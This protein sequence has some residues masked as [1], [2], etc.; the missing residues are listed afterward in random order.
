M[1]KG[2]DIL[3]RSIIAFDTGK[4]IAGILDLIFDQETN[5][6]LGFLVDEG[7]LFH[8]AKV[9]P[10]NQ[11]KAIGPDVIVVSGRDVIVSAPDVPQIQTILEHKLVLK[12]NRIITTDGRYLG[13]IVDL[14]FNDQT[15][16]IEGYETS[17]G[18]FADAYSGRSFIPAPQTVKIGKEVTFVPPETADLMA[19]QVGG[20]RGAMITAGNRIQESTATAGQQLQDATLAANEQLQ[21]TATSANR[22][23]QEV[24]SGANDRFDQGSRS[25]A[26]ELTD[27]LVSPDEQF[28]YVV[29]KPVEG[30][31]QT[32]DGLILLVKHQVV[33]LSLAEEARRLGILDQVY[34]ATGGSLTVGINRQLQNATAQ[35]ESHLQMAA[36]RGNAALSHLAAQAGIE[37]A[38]GRRVQRMVRAEDGMIIAAPGQIVTDNV[39][40]RAKL[41]HRE[42]SLLDAV[43]LQPTEATRY[44]ANDTVSDAGMRVREQA[45]IAQ[46][47][48]YTFW[49]NLK[50]HY[51]EFQERSAKAMHKQRIEQALGRPVNRV[52]LDSQDQVILNVGELITHKAIQQAKQGGV[53]NILLNSVCNRNPEILE[54]ELRAPERGIASLER[55]HRLTP[56]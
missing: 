8:A 49:E 36:Q 22:K 3:N 24:A 47:N 55:E 54:A 21:A 46:E 41:S 42:V 40:E 19:E 7:G 30:D 6:L 14:Y 25:A 45:A 51:R 11:V 15:G 53:L 50:T 34:R 5:Q 37:Q 10:L 29:G 48:A 18:V 1:R 52:I 28:A 23:L 27:R 2:S 43:G 38:R 33:T 12:G 31:I 35:A 44:R 20:I 32:P 26:T 16:N 56:Q 13:S 9:I 17:G 4:R 39:I